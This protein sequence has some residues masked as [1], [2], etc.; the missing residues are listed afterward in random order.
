VKRAAA[1]LCAAILLIVLL[2]GSATA[3][4]LSGLVDVE[5]LPTG[6]FG[7]TNYPYYGGQTFTPT[8]TG[9]LTDVQLNGYFEGSDPATAQPIT[10]EVRTTAGGL[11]TGTILA[12]MTAKPDNT[13]AWFDFRFAVP[14]QVMAGVRYALVWQFAELTA[15]M[16]PTD[17]YYGGSYTGGAGIGKGSG[18]WQF[19]G[20]NW[21][22]RT[23]VYPQ[24][25]TAAWSLGHVD[26]GVST[27]VSLTE[28]FYLGPSAMPLPV[29][30]YIEQTASPSWF[31]VDSVSCSVEVAAADCVKGKV[32]LNVQ[33]PASSAQTWF[34][35]TV[36]ITGT[37]SPLSADIGTIGTAT[38]ELCASG[39]RPSVVPAQAPTDLCVAA[40]ADL[41]VLPVGATPPPGTTA[42]DGTGRSNGSAPWLLPAGLLAMLGAAIAIRHH[43]PAR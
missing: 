28:H 23:F 37:A 35:V 9:Q 24:A 31:A 17:L 7:G 2:P 38:I 39:A 8:M 40:A 5:V 1:A 19:S 25:A 18:S 16:S 29:S 27:T 41:A 26:G 22:L 11:P 33:M 32:A 10:M 36:T 20:H 34:T 6:D 15:G 3:W 4:T 12:T 30:F 14:A 43:R 13:F 21:A 42:R